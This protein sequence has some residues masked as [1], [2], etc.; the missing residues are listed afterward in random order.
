MPAV[1]LPGDVVNASLLGAAAETVNA[2]LV[3]DVSP[4]AEAVS[5]FDPEKFML[6]LANV[7]IPDDVVC[8]VVPPSAPVPLSDMLTDIPFVVRGFPRESS[9]CTVTAGVIIAP[10][11]TAV[12]GCKNTSSFGGRAVIVKGSLVSVVSAPYDARSVLF[13]AVVIFR[14]ANVASPVPPGTC[15]VVPPSVPVPESIDRTTEPEVG[16]ALFPN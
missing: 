5:V 1:L 6:R 11:T 14:S 4:A 9:T 16:S 10:A 8:T 2:P 15:D 12:G 13:P 7:V 3:T